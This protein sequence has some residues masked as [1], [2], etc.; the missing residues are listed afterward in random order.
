MSSD[1]NQTSTIAKNASLAG[2]IALGIVILIA[3]PVF[4]GWS[5][6]NGAVSREEQ[7]AEDKANIDVVVQKR[8]DALSQMINTVKDS[9]KFEE[10]TI[11]KLTEARSQAKTGNVEQSSTILQAT[12]EAYPDLK[13][14]DLYNNVMNE[15]AT[16]ENQ[17]RGAREAYNQDIKSYNQYVR[18]QPNKMI[19]STSGYEVQ[20]YKQFSASAT[21]ENY[22]PT[23]NDLW[24]D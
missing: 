10:E 1:S 24:K 13:T 16:V 12:A 19:L 2:L 20:H 5:I 14:I 17:I 15:T 3:I 22:D 9:K 4:F 11:T 6:Q 7:V 8:V 23:K 18:Q 21:A